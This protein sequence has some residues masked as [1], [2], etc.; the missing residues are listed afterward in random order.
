MHNAFGLYALFGL[1][2][3]LAQNIYVVALLLSAR[4]TV[5]LRHWVTLQV[6]VVALFAP[7]VLLLVGHVSTVQANFWQPFPTASDLMVTFVVYGAGFCLQA[8]PFY[9]SWKAAAIS[10]SIL[11]ALL[12]VIALLLVTRL[13]GPFDWKA[14][15]KALT[16]YS[17]NV[18]VVNV[19]SVL[20]LVVWLFALNVIPFAISHLT[21]PIYVDK[22]TISASV[23]LFLLVAA[24]IRNINWNYARFGVIAVI[25]VLSTASLQAYFAS[26]AKGQAREAMSLID[27]N[28][29]SG[30]VILVF[31]T[32]DHIIFD[33]YNNRTDVAVK[34]IDTWAPS[35]AEN[36]TSEITHSNVMG[37]D[38]VWLF[39]SIPAD[40]ERRKTQESFILD[41][42]N[43]S[44]AKT[45]DKRY[46]L[47]DV[48][49]YEKRA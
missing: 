14:P 18:R 29:E 33:Y 36:K 44:Y 28:V 25:I 1:F 7:F 39:A 2:V 22:Y 23:A 21:H 49:L 16:T 43:E 35:D 30:D 41:V 12:S 31:P 5:R 9:L 46:Y 6:I 10:L 15:L 27:A 19:A 17:W 11:F 42:L 3:V 45:Y 34:Q 13:T 24:G 32:S 37:H 48:Y 38:R 26:N 4:G 40:N 47:Y 8:N 20:F